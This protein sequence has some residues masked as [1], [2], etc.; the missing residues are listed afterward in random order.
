MWR[1]WG[2]RSRIVD[3][4]LRPFR[5]EVAKRI[6]E[7][8]TADRIAQPTPRSRRLTGARV[9]TE[10]AREFFLAEHG[11]EPSRCARAGGADRQG[12]AAAD[13]DGCWL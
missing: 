9:R 3:N 13:A 1:G 8:N 5:V 2:R 6:A 7:L 11:R 10:V 4:D 12:L